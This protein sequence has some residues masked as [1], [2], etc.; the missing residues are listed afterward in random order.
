MAL[1]GATSEFA[2]SDLVQSELISDEDRDRVSAMWQ[3]CVE[4][5]LPM[6]VEYRVKKQWKSVDVAT[7]QEIQG[8]SW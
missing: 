5:K 8:E 7:G 6:M 1:T 4:S 3:T 2:T